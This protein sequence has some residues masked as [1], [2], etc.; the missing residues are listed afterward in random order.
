MAQLIFSRWAAFALLLSLIIPF[1]PVRAEERTSKSSSAVSATSKANLKRRAQRNTKGVANRRVQSN[2]TS[3]KATAANGKERSSPQ[4][5]ANARKQVRRPAKRSATAP[6]PAAPSDSAANPSVAQQ[7]PLA[8]TQ[9]SAAARGKRAAADLNR[10]R[11]VATAP[12][13]ADS[14]AC[15][16]IAEKFAILE[17]KRLNGNSRLEYETRNVLRADVGN[18]RQRPESGATQAN[19]PT[20]VYSLEVWE[21]GRNF[22][23]FE[24]TMTVQGC[25]KVSI[26][27][28]EF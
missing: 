1:Q 22:T 21:S 11:A 25:H 14:E 7:A 27:Q 18:P 28:T 2:T 17:A 10:P 8:P 23:L 3:K 5:R 16:R 13:E 19:G 6:M 12:A 9:A 20:E 15:Q 4:A 24:V 26:K